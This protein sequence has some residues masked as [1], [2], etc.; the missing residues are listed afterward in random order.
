MCHPKI[1]KLF[2]HPIGALHA[3]QLYGYCCRCLGRG[4]LGER[5]QVL[6]VSCCCRAKI[7]QGS[8]IRRPRGSDN[9]KS[10]RQRMLSPG[11]WRENDG[12]TVFHLTNQCTYHSY[13]V[14]QR[15]AAAAVLSLI[16]TSFPTQNNRHGNAQIC[17][18]HATTAP[19]PMGGCTRRIGSFVRLA[20]EQTA[21]GGCPRRSLGAISAAAA[22]LVVAVKTRDT[23]ITQLC[24]R[25]R[26]V[27][28]PQSPCGG[29]DLR[30]RFRILD[31]LLSSTTHS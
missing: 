2:G 6:T 12:N 28:C 21:G 19:T 13:A 5:Q 26:A 8:R 31:Y 1:V 7:S 18:V 15:A 20:A 3:H 17:C 27:I 10:E 9:V 25:C 29:H 11:L 30:H 24:K 14:F 4:L 22:E 23:P 16:F